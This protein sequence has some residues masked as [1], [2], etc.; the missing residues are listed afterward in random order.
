MN[1]FFTFLPDLPPEVFT[2]V[3]EELEEFFGGGDGNVKANMNTGS[4]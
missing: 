2:L 4:F 3:L 1:N